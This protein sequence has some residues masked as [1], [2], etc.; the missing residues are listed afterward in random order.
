MA[1]IETSTKCIYLTVADKLQDMPLRKKYQIRSKDHSNILSSVITNRYNLWF[2]TEGGSCFKYTPDGKYSR[3]GKPLDV[4]Y[5]QIDSFLNMDIAV[6]SRNGDISVYDYSMARLISSYHIDP[7]SKITFNPLGSKFWTLLDNSITLYSSFNKITS[8]NFCFDIHDI[9]MDSDDNLFV[10][11]GNT[12]LVV[13]SEGVIYTSLIFE[14]S[15]RKMVMDWAGGV[16]FFNKDH[17]VY[18]PRNYK[19]LPLNKFKLLDVSS[20]NASDTYLSAYNGEELTMFSVTSN[21]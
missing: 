3:G 20:M 1:K 2:I 5:D 16:L 13:S 17:T 19:N 7:F 18:F 12:V 10:L 6:S 21:L 8:F 9:A 4:K 14:D 11:A 15:Y